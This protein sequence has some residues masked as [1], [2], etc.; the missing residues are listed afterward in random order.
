[1][2]AMVIEDSD[3]MRAILRSVLHDLGFACIGEASDGQDG[4]SR[5]TAFRPDLVLVDRD[6]PTLDGLSIVRALRRVDGDLPIV[7]VS[8]ESARE[9]VVEAIGAGVNDYVVKPFTP[10]TIRAKL[11]PLLPANRRC[12]S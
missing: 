10:T 11:E 8:G 4:L 3:A 6:L 7:M 1:M 9:R 2:R 12:A 5:C